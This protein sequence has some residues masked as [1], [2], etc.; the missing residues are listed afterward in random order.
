MNI[1]K[2]WDEQP[3]AL[4]MV[5]AVIFRLLAAIFAKGW[6]MFDDHYIVIESAQSWVDG[7]DYNSW[8]PWS[9]GNKGPGGHNLF[10]PCLN[11][12]FFYVMKLI[13]VNDPQIKMFIMRLMLASWSLIT[14]YYGYRIT[15]TL[16]GK[17]PAR[18]AGLLLALFWFMP[19]MSVRNLIE[20]VCVPLIT[21]GFWFIVRPQSKD[22]PLLS[23]FISGL[24]FGLATD[25]RLQ[26]LFFPLGLG[27]WLL[28]NARVKQLLSLTAGSLLTFALFEGGI[29][30]I[31]WGK[32]F[33]EL[34]TYATTSFSERNDYISLPWYD[35]FLV[36]GGLLIPPV[37][38]FLSW[39]FIRK[40]KEYFM[41]FLPVAI[42]FVFH[43]WVPNKQERFI[44]PMIP[45]FIMIGCIGWAEF[46]EKSAW[47]A[48][49][50]KLLRSCWIFFWVLNSIGLLVFTFTY[51]K[52]S[53]AESMTY[54]SK[55]PDIRYMTAIDG[56]NNP[57]MLP[58][59]YLGQ[60][61]EMANEKNGDRSPDSILVA[62]MRHGAANAP[63]FVLFTGESDISPLVIK[64]RK[65]LPGLVY[66]TTIEPGFIDKFVHWLNPI[67]RNKTVYIYR[68]TDFIP[69]KKQ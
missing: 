46:S 41:I 69:E 47:W 49:H 7:F 57:E 61:P 40:W 44:I 12:L 38:I 27:I 68:N 13:Q 42:F 65:Y 15:E 9:Q 3:L 2:Y 36:I 53:Y 56:E 11:F 8:F 33:I 63:C 55:Y 48:K 37:S 64:A 52:R 50:S 51:S 32:P 35:F 62:S 26:S 67:N 21:L 58:K 23:W 10:Y 29:D 17:K 28:F 14:V 4:I 39:G 25:I 31:I 6:G 5:L 66:E 60:W 1:R 24:L 16:G 59:F 34:Y 45:V 19:W 43:S 20:M 30:F 54:L 22:K 18:M